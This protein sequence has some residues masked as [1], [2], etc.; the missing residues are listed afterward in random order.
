VISISNKRQSILVSA[1]ALGLLSATCSA[2]ANNG[3]VAKQL[4]GAP[5]EFALMQP[6]DPAAAAIHSKSALIPIELG[7]QKDGRLGWQGKLPVENGNLRFL[8]F[9][10]NSGAWQVDLS[11]PTGDLEKS[12]AELARSVKRT[13]FGI[14]Q[15]RFPADYYTLEGV[16]NGAWSL[17]ISATQGAPQ[18]GFLL[19]EGNERTELASYQ[20]HTRQLVGERIGLAARLTATD[21]QDKVLLGAAAG[22]IERAELRVTYPNGS[23]GLSPMFDDG[24]HADGAAGDGVFGGEF[25]A[26]SGGEHMAQVIIHGVDRTGLP[27]IRTAEHPIPVVSPS[28]ALNGS[29]A[30][31]KAL[32]EQGSR[33]LIQI[34]VEGRKSGQHYRAYAEVWGT[35][36]D[37]SAVPVAWVSGMSS[38]KDGALD[39]G[40]DERWVTRSGATAPFE[41][42]KLRIEDPD[43]F[44]TITGAERLPV[45]LP[46]GRV[47]AKAED[48]VIDEAMLMG[49]RPP[50]LRQKGVGKRLLLVHGYCSGGVWP[51]GQFSTAS[52]FLDVNQNRT[53]DQFARLIQTFG[54]TWNSFGVVAHSQG[55]AAAL[56]LYT[57][58]WSG[59]DNATGNRLIQ[60]VGTPYK[61]TNLAGILASLGSW[62]GVGCGTNS[63]LSY[64][65]AA[66]WL[67]GIPT[68]SRAKVNYYTTAFRSTNWWTN[69]YCNFATDLVLSDPEDGTTEQTNGQLPSGV[70]RGHTTGQCHTAGMRDPAQYQ[71]ASRNSVMNSNG[72]R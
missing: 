47:K 12:A 23:V 62:F 69:D 11:T 22:R 37:G 55:G 24:L 29:W 59:L 43:H 67:A 17:K 58:Y 35:G 66:S 36:K 13:A 70:N 2:V 38:P 61:G 64:S 39:L 72:A 25:H 9:A 4:A 56:H 18:R 6:L 10:E 3:P 15:A 33:S 42:R 51:A 31:A 5:G 8:V 26:K 16:E 14:E 20:T 30:S 44:V 45:D 27:L 52:T 68:S 71:D 34:P 28:I 1:I 46:T 53:H 32:P 65:G 7:M 50:E 40:F 41:L 21:A 49:P 63:N 19:I 54:N 60:S 48:I 57:Y